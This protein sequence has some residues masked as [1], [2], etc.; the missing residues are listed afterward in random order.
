MTLKGSQHLTVAVV[1]RSPGLPAIPAAPSGR[2]QRRS[3][4]SRTAI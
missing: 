4:P 3:C 2:V 1:E